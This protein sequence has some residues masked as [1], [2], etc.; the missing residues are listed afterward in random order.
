VPERQQE[1]TQAGPC[2]LLFRSGDRAALGA[3]RTFSV[4]PPVV[5]EVP[6]PS[7]YQLIRHF[8]PFAS[9]KGGRLGIPENTYNEKTTFGCGP[10][11]NIR[12]RVSTFCR[13]EKL[14]LE[15]AIHFKTLLWRPQGMLDSV[16]SAS[17]RDKTFRGKTYDSAN[18]KEDS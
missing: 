7:R 2:Q 4:T 16:T 14:K 6:T 10:G 12:G 5:S 3:R 11:D 13:H 15:I 9:E 8:W 1:E 18:D 17:G